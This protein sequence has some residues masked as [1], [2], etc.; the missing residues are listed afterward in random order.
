MKT[1]LSAGRWGH[2]PTHSPETRRDTPVTQLRQDTTHQQASATPAKKPSRVNALFN[3]AKNCTVLFLAFF[4]GA[5]LYD[6]GVGDGPLPR[7]QDISTTAPELIPRLELNTTQ[8]LP[9]ESLTL[10]Q[11]W[12]ALQPTLAILEATAPEIADWVYQQ[13]R[14]GNI[15]LAKT[16]RLNGQFDPHFKADMDYHFLSGKI[17][18]T[19]TMWGSSD[20]VKAGMLVH[21]YRHARQNPVKFISESLSDAL[22]GRHRRYTSRIEDEAF[23]YE[24]FFLRSLGVDPSEDFEIYFYR[25]AMD[26]D[27]VLRHPR[28]VHR[29]F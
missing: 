13:Y 18:L 27:S 16:S 6:K 5:W 3:S 1:F 19:E 29:Q 28:P 17:T 7:F 15:R 20:A 9:L 11:A 8:H 24:H 12:E 22:T 2:R 23:L 26:T 4:G 25:K 14:D 21:E 10:P